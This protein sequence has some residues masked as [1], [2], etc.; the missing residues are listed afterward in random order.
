[1]RAGPRAKVSAELNFREASQA[2]THQEADA[3]RAVGG[4]GK[5]KP[6]WNQLLDGP[7]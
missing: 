4:D 3:L 6:E 7:T 1:M 5:R 2:V